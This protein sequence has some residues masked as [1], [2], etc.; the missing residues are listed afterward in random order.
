MRELGP[1]KGPQHQ[2]VAHPRL[3]SGPRTPSPVFSLG[4]TTS[5][6]WLASLTICLKSSR[7]RCSL[8][9][10]MEV[11]QGIQTKWHHTRGREALKLEISSFAATNNTGGGNKTKPG[12]KQLYLVLQKT[13]PYYRVAVISG[14]ATGR[15]TVRTLAKLG[16]SFLLGAAGAQSLTFFPWTLQEEDRS[17]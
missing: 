10:Q 13:E 12:A 5:H 7:A 15:P 17:L 9:Q 1:R 8:W 11:N 2:P 3:D 4:L 6:T 14:Q 16:Q